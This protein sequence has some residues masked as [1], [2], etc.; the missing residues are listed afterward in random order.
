ME[1]KYV[2]N[3]LIYIELGKKVRNYR[4]AMNL[5]QAQLATKAGL[6]KRAVERIESGESRTMDSF[7]MV[8]RAF[9]LIDNLDLLIPNQEIRPTDLVKKVPQKKRV[10]LSKAKEAS[11]ISTA[12]FKWGD[13]E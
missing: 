13:E 6:S 10:R 8:L 7:F 12:K 9:N 2:P 5:T 11:G 4:L 3:D 1:Y